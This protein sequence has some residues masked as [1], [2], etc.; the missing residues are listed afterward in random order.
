M[1]EASGN[2]QRL[3]RLVEPGRLPIGD[4]CDLE[5]RIPKNCQRLRPLCPKRLACGCTWPAGKGREGYAGVEAASGV[6]RLRRAPFLEKTRHSC[7][8]CLG[9]LGLRRCGICP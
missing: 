9:G 4:L 3:R 8:E 7:M 6:E 2:G 1:S 5:S